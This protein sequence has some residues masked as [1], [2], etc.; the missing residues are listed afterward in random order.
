MDIRWQD[1]TGDTF[2]LRNE[3]RFVAYLHEYRPHWTEGQEH[4][5]ILPKSLLSIKVMAGTSG[6]AIE[7]IQLNDTAL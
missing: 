3:D 6:N 7:S 5:E 4:S 1:D 2:A